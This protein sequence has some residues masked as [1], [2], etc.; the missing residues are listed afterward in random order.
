M[1]ANKDLLTSINA[2][3]DLRKKITRAV[4]LTIITSI[5]FTLNMNA[6]T[7]ESL[8][9][10]LASLNPAES[11]H[12]QSLIRDLHPSVNILQGLYKVSGPGPAEVATCDAS[13]VSLLYENNPIF[14]QVELI[15]I[16][17]NSGSDLPSS[18]DITQL[19]SFTNLDYLLFVFSYDACG[20]QSDQCLSALLGKIIRKGSS[21]IITTGMQGNSPQSTILYS[22]SIPE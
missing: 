15:K 14:N 19:Q 13:S 10:K 9:S 20:G 11:A 3:L 7:I 22:L 1:K 21:P 2:I 17:I 8:E 16:N 12:L 18:I 6:Q 5:A 4:L